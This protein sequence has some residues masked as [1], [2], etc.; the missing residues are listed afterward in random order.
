MTK[1][2]ELYLIDER[3]GKVVRRWRVEGMPEGKVQALER[4]IRSLLGEEMLLRDS[5]FDVE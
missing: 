3:T 2:R 4:Q 5:A 1:P